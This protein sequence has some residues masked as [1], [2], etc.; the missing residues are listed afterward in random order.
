VEDEQQ[1]GNKAP[2]NINLEHYASSVPVD[3]FG[4]KEF[5]DVIGNVWQWSQTPIYPFEGFEVH[6]LYDDFTMPTFDN[7]HN[8]IKGGSWISTGNETQLSSRYAFR[9]HFFQHAGFRY[10]SSSYN[11]SIDANV[12]ES[13]ES[14]AMY[15]NMSWGK[16]YFG[17]KNFKAAC[18]QIAL[19]HA[20]NFD[21]ALDIG[22]ALGRGTFELAKSFEKVVGVDYTA[23]FI[24]N[25]QKMKDDKRL[26]FWVKDEGEIKRFYEVHLRDFDL[27]NCV[28][29]VEF[30]QGDACNLKPVFSGYDLVF[31][32]NLIDRLYDPRKFLTEIMERVNKD[33]IL[34]LASPYSWDES[35]TPRQKWLG[36]F[37][38]DGEN[39]TTFDG[40]EQIL[41]E[42]FE[43]IE[44]EDV[45]FVIQ[46]SSRKFQH[47]ISE[48]S[49]WQKR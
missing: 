4:F 28:D 12:Y 29:K 3:R 44:R 27:Q 40:I 24:Q 38:K 22:C 19:E 14:V 34:L 35:Y 25:A 13:D 18:A 10:V 15:A 1:W 5:Y 16:E 45:T 47:S 30:W 9:R 23:R 39:Y 20:K 36:G 2:A 6:P 37:K 21:K 26:N 17:V 46:E 42:K 43:L 8:I 31:A 41:Q 7:Q 49:V 48:V 33:G 11:E 32:T